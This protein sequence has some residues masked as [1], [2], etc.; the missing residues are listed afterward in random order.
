MTYAGSVTLFISVGTDPGGGSATSGSAGCRAVCCLTPRQPVPA[1]DRVS[2]KA[3]PDPI[4]MG[5]LRSQAI[6]PPRA[7]R[8]PATRRMLSTPI[9]ASL[10]LFRTTHTCGTTGSLCRVCPDDDLSALGAL[11]FETPLPPSWYFARTSDEPGR[12]HPSWNRGSARRSGD[13]T[14]TARIVGNLDYGARA[15]RYPINACRTRAVLALNPLGH[16]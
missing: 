3:R 11:L 6:V 2:T 5:S 16:S 1:I 8:G 4:R 15:A 7:R 14:K 13:L 10:H 12:A 9:G